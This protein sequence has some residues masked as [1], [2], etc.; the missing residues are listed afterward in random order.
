MKRKR[1]TM[2]ILV[3]IIATIVLAISMMYNSGVLSNKE[4]T[5][6]EDNIKKEKEILNTVKV[7]EDKI[8]EELKEEISQDLKEYI[9][10]TIK[11]VIFM[12]EE[13]N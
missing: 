7:E 1:L 9:Y 12:V 2:S 3:V 6:S 11:I 10:L 5:S 13:K 4:S 8:L